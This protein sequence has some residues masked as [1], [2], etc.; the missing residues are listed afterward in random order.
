MR[1][2]LSVKSICQKVVAM[3]L[4]YLDMCNLTEY[5]LAINN[6]DISNL[7]MDSLDMD[8]LDIINLGMYNPDMNDL[9]IPRMD[10]AMRYP[11]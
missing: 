5:N 9:L 6:L 8:R 11:K 10:V 4:G 7:D 1:C 3:P 2:T